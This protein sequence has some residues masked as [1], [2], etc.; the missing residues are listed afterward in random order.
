MWFKDISYLELLQPFYSG[1]QNHL[2]NL[3]RGHHEEHFC[4]IILN[5]DQWFRRCHLKVF[6]PRAL[7]EQNRCATFGRGHYGEHSCEIILNLD[8]WFRRRYS[9]KKKFTDD[10]QCTTHA[11]R[12][13]ITIEHLELSAQVSLKTFSTAK[14]WI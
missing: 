7:A 3:G 13:P 2:C 11:R 9:L 1:K 6:L 14:K 8:Q 5:L 4:E 12:R 10:A